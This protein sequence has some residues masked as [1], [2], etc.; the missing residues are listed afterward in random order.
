[1]V[2]FQSSYDRYRPAVARD[3]A[4]AATWKEVPDGG[5]ETIYNLGAHVIDQAY[6]LFG[7]PERVGCRVWDMRNSGLAEAVRGS[8][9]F[10][11]LLPAYLHSSL[12]RS[13]PSSIVGM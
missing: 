9:F 1:M 7:K 8:P 4:R 3:P 2:E 13:G 5:N 6:L 10:R 12:V 11:R